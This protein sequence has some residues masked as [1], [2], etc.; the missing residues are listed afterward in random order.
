[1]PPTT[2]EKVCEA[3]AAQAVHVSAHA[4]TEALDDGLDILELIASTLQGELVEDYPTDPRGASCLVLSRV[5]Q[6]PVHS[7]WGY[8]EQASRAI[9]ITVYK[10]E[11]SRWSEDFR[12]R[13]PRT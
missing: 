8:D 7:V 9:V 1:M 4:Y 10:P 2:F 12:T 5:E 13:L 11:P 6:E 3:I